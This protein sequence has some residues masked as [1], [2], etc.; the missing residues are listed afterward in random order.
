MKI[1]VSTLTLF[2]AITSSLA[3][4]FSFGIKG[5]TNYNFSGD[6]NELR[7][8]STDTDDIIHKAKSI[9]GYHGGLYAKLGDDIFIRAEAVYTHFENEFSDPAMYTITTDKLDI[10]VVLGMKVLGPLYIFAGPDFQYIL[11]EDFY[12]ND[13]SKAKETYKEFT[14]G[15][16]LGVGVAFGRFALDFRWDKGLSE[17]SIDIVNSEIG[18]TYNFTVDNRPNQLLL[19][20][21]IALSQSN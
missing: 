19:S 11:N 20:L 15:L 18:S 4:D 12:E 2:I 17:N 3:Q 8:F 16:H 13:I 6:L 14:T 10:P 1:L 9:R 7:D 21:N 5:G